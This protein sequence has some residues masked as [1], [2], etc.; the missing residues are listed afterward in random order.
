MD[1]CFAYVFSSKVLTRLFLSKIL[2][3]NCLV[4]ENKKTAKT[5]SFMEI[6]IKH[7]KVELNSIRNIHG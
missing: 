1:F 3:L 5:Q 2:G 6:F 7:I 4:W